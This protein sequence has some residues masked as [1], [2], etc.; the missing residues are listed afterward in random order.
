MSNHSSRDE[1]FGT[2]ESFTLLEHKQDQAILKELKHT[3][4]FVKNQ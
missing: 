4:N 3:T 2:T 1:I